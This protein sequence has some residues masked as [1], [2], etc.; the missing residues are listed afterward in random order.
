MELKIRNRIVNELIDTGKY[1]ALPIG[2]VSTIIDDA[3]KE[4]KKYNKLK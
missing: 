3:I 2:T 1:Q 4:L